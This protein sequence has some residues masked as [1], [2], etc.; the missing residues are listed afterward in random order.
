MKKVKELLADNCKV[1]V[2]IVFKG[3]E[4]SHKEIGLKNLQKF[5][6]PE[7]NCSEIKSEGNTLSISLTPK[8]MVNK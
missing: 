2:S 7:A 4:N 8:I 3:R 1:N 5:R 6:I